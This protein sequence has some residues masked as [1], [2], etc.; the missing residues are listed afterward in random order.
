[1]TAPWDHSSANKLFSDLSG[2]RHH[3]GHHLKHT[4]L[5]R[6]HKMVYFLPCAFLILDLKALKLRETSRIV[7]NGVVIAPD[8][9]DI[10][11]LGET[12]SRTHKSCT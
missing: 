11:C 7:E 1:M 3:V 2:A 12:L 6:G 10:G 9:G 4:L 5:E 8:A